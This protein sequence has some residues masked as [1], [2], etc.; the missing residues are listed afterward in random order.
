MFQLLLKG[1]VLLVHTFLISSILS[2]IN[3]PIEENFNTYTKNVN[4][5]IKENFNTPIK[6]FF[7]DNNTINNNKFNIL[8]LLCFQILL[9]YYY[10]NSKR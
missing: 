10:N 2:P 5:P 4:D 8:L 7:K 9:R 6:V 3:I 1:Y